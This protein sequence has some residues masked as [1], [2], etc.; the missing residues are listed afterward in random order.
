MANAR[1]IEMLRSQHASEVQTAAAMRAQSDALHREM[2]TLRSQLAAADDG[3]TYGPAGLVAS[4]GGPCFAAGGLAV[5]FEQ[6]FAESE[7][8]IPA[9]AAA[10]AK[11]DVA[12]AAPL[13]DESHRLTVEKLRNTVAETEWLPQEARRLGADAASAFGAGFGGSCWAIA[14]AGQADELCAQWRAAY[15]AAFPER[16]GAATFFVMRPGPGACSV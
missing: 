3:Q 11:G 6:F 8:I 2:D 7:Q 15:V 5:R 14:S 16:S 12:A 4:A 1:D 13:V 10:L 9:V